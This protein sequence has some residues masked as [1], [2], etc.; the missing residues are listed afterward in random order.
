[1]TAVSEVESGSGLL[2]F[3]AEQQRFEV[4]QVRIGGRPG[5]RPTV[6]IGSIFYQGQAIV[7]DEQRGEFAKDEARKLL[8]IQEDYAKRTGNPCM[9]DVVAGTAEAMR[10]YLTFAAG[11][12]PIPLLIDGTTADV[13]RAG[14][15]Y[16]ASAGLGDR[17]VYNSIQ[18]GIGDDELAAIGKAG[19]ENAILL[20]F[21]GKHLTAEARVSA[22]RELLPRVRR[23]GIR[24]LLV[25]TCVFA[26]PSLGQ[27][28]RALVDVKDEFGLPAGCGVHNAISM[29]Q[30]LKAN[31]GPLARHACSAAVAAATAAVGADFVLYG[32]IEDAPVV[33]PAVATSDT[34]LS[35]LEVEA[36]RVLEKDHPRFRIG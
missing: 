25:D 11:A 18:P 22:V 15:E 21:R 8:R 9:L 14:L 5:S 17:I 31:L 10:R 36:G 6:L 35:E 13:R 24:N 1:M 32:P 34:A 23:A 16:V 29:W 3:R 2:R 12:T 19:V 20:A 33:F 4:G 28:W 7:L 30:D 27:A 26:L